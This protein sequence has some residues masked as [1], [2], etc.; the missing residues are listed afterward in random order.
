MNERM[1][2]LIA[3]SDESTRSSVKDTLTKYNY[4]VLEATSEE[5]TLA[6]LDKTEE[7]IDVVLL[8]VNPKQPNPFNTLRAIKENPTTENTGIILLIESVDP[9]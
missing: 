7:T 8:N 2:I 9:E 4:D 5:D 6:L 3:D 1:K